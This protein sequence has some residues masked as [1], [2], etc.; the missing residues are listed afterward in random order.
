M[1]LR[2]HTIGSGVRGERHLQPNAG[3]GADCLQQQL[4]PGVRRQRLC[5]S[6]HKTYLLFGSSRR[7]LASPRAALRLMGLDIKSVRD[8]PVRIARGF[9]VFPHVLIGD[10][11][12]RGF[13]WPL[14]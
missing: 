12:E 13:R 6:H 4:R 8:F 2:E 9:V 11:D 14:G 7:R 3:P 5:G 10:E 1:D